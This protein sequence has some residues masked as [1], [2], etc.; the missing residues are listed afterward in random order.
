MENAL[1]V[2]NLDRTFRSELR[3]GIPDSFYEADEQNSSRPNPQIDIYKLHPLSA[4]QRIGT[5][6]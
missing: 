5:S 6:S 2:G 3:P 4:H 1:T